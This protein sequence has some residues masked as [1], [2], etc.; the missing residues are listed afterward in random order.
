MTDYGLPEDPHL[1]ALM[2][3]AAKGQ[4]LAAVMKARRPTFNF[5]APM[6]GRHTTMS[7]DTQAMMTDTLVTHEAAALAGE[8]LA[9]FALDASGQPFDGDDPAT[10]AAADAAAPRIV[11]MGNVRFRILDPDAR[12]LAR[13]L[14]AFDPEAEHEAA[15]MLVEFEEG[16][17]DSPYTGQYVT[18]DTTEGVTVIFMVWVSSAD[19][20]DT[21]GPDFGQDAAFNPALDPIRLHASRALLVQVFPDEE[22]GNEN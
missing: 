3:A 16:T 11:S 21:T 13:E 18:L 14:G 2:H 1:R 4:T 22:A 12:E 5:T 10:W 19:L 17:A 7:N 9:K 15:A 8:V 6:K 20:N